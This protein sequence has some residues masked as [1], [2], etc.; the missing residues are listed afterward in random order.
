M[1]R[2]RGP[3]DPAELRGV[4]AD[5]EVPDVDV[6][7]LLAGVRDRIQRRRDRRRTAGILAAG[8]ATA[9]VA[10]VPIVV[11][12]IPD[13]DHSTT[14]DSGTSTGSTE[15]SVLSLP[16]D[17][18]ADFDPTSTFSVGELPSDYVVEY[19]RNEPGVQ[20]RIYLAPDDEQ[21]QVV[22][23]YFDP[24][25]SGLPAPLT[26]PHPQTVAELEVFPMTL[27]TAGSEQYGLAWQPEPDRWV[28]LTST[29]SDEPARQ[30]LLDLIPSIDVGAQELLS[31]PIQAGYIPE[32]FGLLAAYRDVQADPDEGQL[33]TNLVL[34]DQLAGQPPGGT[35]SIFVENDP[36]EPT[37][38]AQAPTTTV[39]G[40][41]ARYGVDPDGNQC[42]TVYQVEGMSYLVCA[43][44]ELVGRFAEDDLRRIAAGIVVIPG[45]ATDPSVW[46]E[47]PLP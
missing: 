36:Q 43:S 45:A 34:V 38:G 46:T 44:S 4:F 22:I 40:N 19:S 30:E 47:Q 6:T 12:S 37:T 33:R 15:P 28:T 2:S 18:T 29:G 7:G 9:L 16:T 10:A 21:K 13:D 24:E 1:T 39:S 25:L 3:R 41:P 17:G 32:G 31:F 42:F 14:A 20:T 11:S 5:H 23:T 8:V 27:D 35:L 26:A